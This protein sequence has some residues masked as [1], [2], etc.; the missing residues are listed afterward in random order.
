MNNGDM[1]SRETLLSGCTDAQRIERDIADSLQQY[2]FGDWTAVARQ[3]GMNNTTRLIETDSGRYALRLYDNHQDRGIVTLEHEMLHYLTSSSFSLKVPEPVRNS[4]GDT[5]TASSSGKLASL[6]R[7][8]EGERPL[9]RHEAHVRSLGRATGMLSASLAQFQS[10]H[11]PIYKPYYELDLSY[12]DWSDEN[13]LA[14][15]DRSKLRQPEMESV[16]HLLETRRSMSTFLE[17]VRSLPHQW[18]HGDLNFSNAVAV[19]EEIVGVLDFEFCTVDLR[20]MEPA[21]VL[22]DFIHADRSDEERMAYLSHYAVGYGSACK[23]TRDETDAVPGLMKLRMLDVFLH[24]A[25][26]RSDELDE[27]SVWEGQ[28]RHADSVCRWID[29]YE[30][31]MKETLRSSLSE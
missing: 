30:P 10:T 16:R 19:E 4:T 22:V 24:F 6:F 28:I 18:I 29:S 15:A 20:A 31:V 13:V 9:S 7:Y 25:G 3:S 17:S 27:V 8:I 11:A 2:G 26:R 1:D 14:L 5:I 23:L 12:S 21:V